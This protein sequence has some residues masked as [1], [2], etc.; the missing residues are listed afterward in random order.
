MPPLNDDKLLDLDDVRRKLAS[1]HGRTYWRGL[2]ELAESPAFEELL[3][4]EFPRQASELTADPITRR[5]FLTLMAASLALA[6]L[7]GCAR[8]PGAKILPYVRQP[9][10]MV[11]GRPLFFA[12]AM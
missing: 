3:H 5:R 11:P 12:T 7:T 6:G 9:E 2:E 4:R 8:Q 1:S 10:G